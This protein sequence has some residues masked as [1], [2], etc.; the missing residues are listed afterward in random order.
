MGY[1]PEKIP[2]INHATKIELGTMNEIEIVGE[3]IQN[4]QSFVPLPKGFFSIADFHNPKLWRKIF[5]ST[6]E[7]NLKWFFNKIKTRTVRL[8]YTWLKKQ[9]LA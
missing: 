8:T 9:N 4:I 2:I 3:K 5:Y 6:L 7:T 1:L